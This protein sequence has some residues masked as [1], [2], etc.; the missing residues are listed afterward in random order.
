MTARLLQLERQGKSNAL[1]TVPE[2]EQFA[3]LS[4]AAKELLNEVMTRFL[5]SARV[6]H[7]LMKVARTLA[8]L[9]GAGMTEERHISEVLQYRCLDRVRMYKN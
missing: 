8:D 9:E 5:F 7:R 4:V 6:Y 3:C 1:L 2:L